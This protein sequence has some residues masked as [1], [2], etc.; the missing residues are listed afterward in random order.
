[1]NTKENEE[2]G[3][4]VQNLD[5]TVME[6]NADASAPGGQSRASRSMRRSMRMRRRRRTGGMRA[7]LERTA[8]TVV[9]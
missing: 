8:R 9:C 7:V 3:V 4:S 2:N 5:R 1:M 6:Q